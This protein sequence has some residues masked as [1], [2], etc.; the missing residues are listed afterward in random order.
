MIVDALLAILDF[1]MGIIIGMRPEWE[2]QLPA[3]I[4]DAI[5]YVRELDAVVPATELVAVSAITLTAFGIMYA[6]KWILKIADWI[7]DIIP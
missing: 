5:L 2:P 1:L 7:A 3:G 4:M 6:W